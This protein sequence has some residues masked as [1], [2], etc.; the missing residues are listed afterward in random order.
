METVQSSDLWT[1]RAVVVIV[2]I[3]VM[4]MLA[5]VGVLSYQGKDIPG[6]V[7]SLLPTATVALVA[8]LANTRG[9]NA[10]AA[11]PKP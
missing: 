8:L 9:S 2:G 6:V 1:Q 3:V 11:E 5:L 7:G 4:V 10:P